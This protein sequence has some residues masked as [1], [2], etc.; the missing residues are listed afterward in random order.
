MRKETERCFAT[1][2]LDRLAYNYDAV[3]RRTSKEVI[4]VVKADAY[5]HGAQEVAGKLASC[6]C[7]GFAVSTSDEAE[8]LRNAGIGGEI[9]VLGFVRDFGHAKDIG[10]TPVVYDERSAFL[11]KKYDL[12]VALK[13]NTGM[14]R[15]GFSDYEKALKTAKLLKTVCV[16]TH[17]AAADGKSDE[18]KEFTRIQTEKFRRFETLFRNE[19]NEN[20]RFIAA[21]SAAAL[22]YGGIFDGTR[23]GIALYGINPVENTETELLPVMSLYAR[24][25]AVNRLKC[26]EYVG[27]GLQYRAAR[28]VTSAVVSAGYADGVPRAAAE[29]GSVFFKG[30]KRRFTGRISMDCFSFDA[31]DTNASTGDI[32][33]IFGNRLSVIETA[34]ASDTVPYEIFTGIS[35]RVP[36]IYLGTNGSVPPQKE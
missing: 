15:L 34:E 30:G 25:I 27:Y 1:V 32:V 7:G 36:R 5:G 3:K 11:A 12:P 26:G 31:T 20:V 14:N 8:E 6:G 33:E 22:A 35:K 13:L 21:N 28:D 4:A 23:A 19:S 17:F 18:E 29:K 10:I 24:I 2:Y 16:F 9:F